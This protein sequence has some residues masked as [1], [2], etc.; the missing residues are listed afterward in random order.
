MDVQNILKRI[1]LCSR[2]RFF[3]ETNIYM[4]KNRVYIM[5]INIRDNITV[6]IVYNMIFIIV[7][8]YVR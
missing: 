2:K 6:N 5:Y 1:R 4:K 7:A 8:V 3:D